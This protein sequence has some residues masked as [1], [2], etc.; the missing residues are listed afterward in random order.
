MTHIPV[1][2]LKQFLAFTILLLAGTEAH[3]QS[4]LEKT[5]GI[6]T[7][8]TFTSASVELPVQSQAIVKRGLAK[9]EY[10]SGMDAGYGYGYGM[11]CWRLEFTTTVKIK[12]LHINN[13]R[14]RKQYFSFNLCDKDGETLLVAQL[15]EEAIAMVNNGDKLLTYSINLNSIPLILLDKTQSIR[16]EKV[17]EE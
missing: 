17:F 10:N 13:D 16:I 8:F 11:E 4:L 6:T 2:I 1:A 5:G 9:F 14:S 7:N 15:D 3:S 12:E